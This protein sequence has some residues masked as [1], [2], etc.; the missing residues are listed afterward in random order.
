[1][2]R[3]RL[4]Q[5]L[6]N[7]STNGSPD[8]ANASPAAFE[9]WDQCHS[10]PS[11]IRL[12][13]VGAGEAG[14]LAAYKARCMLENYSLVCYERNPSIGGTRWE[15]RYPGCACDIPAHTYTYTFEPNLDW[16]GYYAHSYEIQEYFERFYEKY[17][18]EPFVK[19]NTEVVSASWN[20]DEEKWNVELRSRD[21]ATGETKAFQ[22]WCHVLI[23]GSA[24]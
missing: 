4:E 12:I 24:S 18:L 9:I 3:H 11:H 23:N 7:L 6:S 17:E 15:N 1:M 5:M 21:P 22:D 20:G 10:S 13:H 14:L 19:L 16:S 8:T 2:V